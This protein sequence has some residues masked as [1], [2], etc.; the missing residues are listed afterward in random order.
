MVK[1]KWILGPLVVLFAL[2]FVGSTSLH[3]SKWQE[4]DMHINMVFIFILIVD[5]LTPDC[6]ENNVGC[7]PSTCCYGPENTCCSLPS[8]PNGVGCCPILGVS[9]YILCSKVFHDVKM[10]YWNSHRQSLYLQRG[11]IG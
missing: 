10:S 7:D 6:G 8:A 3:I 2:A 5:F 11:E 1:M 9:K 4:I